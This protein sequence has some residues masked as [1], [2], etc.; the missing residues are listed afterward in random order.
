MVLWLRAAAADTGGQIE[1]AFVGRREQIAE[2]ADRQEERDLA[3]GLRFGRSGRGWSARLELGLTARAAGGSPV[4]DPVGS[5]AAA[6]SRTWSLRVRQQRS[7]DGTRLPV[8]E[9]TSER[10]GGPGTGVE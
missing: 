4:P 8:R 7:G 2:G 3:D 9:G 10:G 6:P 1:C 5:E